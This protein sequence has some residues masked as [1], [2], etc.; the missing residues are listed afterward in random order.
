MLSAL[1]DIFWI[2]F[3]KASDFANLD[4]P[5]PLATWRDHEAIVDAIVARDV[6]AARARLAAHYSGIRE[7]VASNQPNTSG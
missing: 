3:Y 4:N 1:I 2:A 7:V 6:A 5:N